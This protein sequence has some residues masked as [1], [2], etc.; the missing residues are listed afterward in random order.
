VTDFDA[1]EF[2]GERLREGSRYFEA[3][4]Q[5]ANDPQP[6]KPRAEAG[7]TPSRLND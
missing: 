1:L 3:I 2:T 6:A 7:S 5:A 4:A